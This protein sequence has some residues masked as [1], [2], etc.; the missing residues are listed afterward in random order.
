MLLSYSGETAEV[1]D[2]ALILKADG[3]RLVGISKSDDSSLG[4]LCDAHIELGDLAEA[5]PHDLA[6]TASTTAMLAVGDAL[7]LALSRRR[8]FTA[9]DFHKHHPGGMLG[10]GLRPLAEVLR[11]RVGENLACVDE[12]TTVGDSL[13]HG[14]TGRRAGAVVVVDGRGALAG[15]FTDGD[16]RRL[17]HE[18]GASTLGLPIGTVMTRAPRALPIESLVRDAVR[19][20]RERRIDEIPVVDAQG[21]PLGLIDVQDLIALRVV[22]V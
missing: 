4:R 21:R 11:F 16:L 10:A 7:A 22:S 8:N 18:R 14:T 3:V 6:P 13:A 1:V 9:D 15:I 2:L 20:V 17:L 19:M 5:C 12:S